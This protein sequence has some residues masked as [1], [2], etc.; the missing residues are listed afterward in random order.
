MHHALQSRRI[1]AGAGAAGRPYCAG[2]TSIFGR[3]GV[4]WWH[5][6]P[7]SGHRFRSYIE[8]WHGCDFMYDS[9]ALVASPVPLQNGHGEPSS[10]MLPPP[11]HTAHAPP[12]SPLPP[13][14]ARAAAAGK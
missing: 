11:P 10:T 5:L 3:L 6:R 8:H 14:A 1:L 7:H 9:A 2:P 12:P 13:I 4:S